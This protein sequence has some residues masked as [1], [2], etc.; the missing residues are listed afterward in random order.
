MLSIG[1][2]RS[3]IKD[4]QEND[5]ILQAEKEQMI[6]NEARYQRLHSSTI[7]HVLNTPKGTSDAWA[8][9]NGVP[10]LNGKVGGVYHSGFK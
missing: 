9:A 7:D 6:Y 1:K 10:A 2:M 3:W 5:T 8:A 4:L